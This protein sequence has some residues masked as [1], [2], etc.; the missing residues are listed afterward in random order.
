MSD[1]G[2]VYFHEGL[3]TDLGFAATGFAAFSL[4]MALGRFIGDGLRARIPSVQL[5]RL[6][7]AIAATGLVIA[8]LLGNPLA[9]LVG[10]ACVGIGLSN[11]IPVV[12]SAAGQTGGMATGN[13]V[14]AVATAGYFGFLVG[15]PS[16]GYVAQ[17]TTLPL[18][19]G[20]VVGFLGLIAMLAGNVRLTE[21]TVGPAGAVR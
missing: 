1:W 2:A 5:V 13:A 9:A 20:L 12:F 4:T 21:P 7:G 3:G 8:L 11:V 10:F 17:A 15:P 14:A 16:I 18:G 6:S 19:L